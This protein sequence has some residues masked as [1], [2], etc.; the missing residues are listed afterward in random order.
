VHEIYGARALELVLRGERPQE[1]ILD[2]LSQPEHYGDIV[3][4]IRR[5]L[6]KRHSYAARLQ[7]LINIVES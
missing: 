2:I 3:M 6:A 4:E 5:H 1:K 7:E